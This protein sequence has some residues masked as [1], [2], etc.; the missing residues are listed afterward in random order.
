MQFVRD[1]IAAPNSP[2]APPGIAPSLARLAYNRLGFG[3]RPGDP[4]FNDAVALNAYIDAQINIEAIDDATC[5]AAVAALPRK[6]S[7]GGDMPPLNGTTQQIKAYDD[8]SEGRDVYANGEMSN[9]LIKVTHMRALLSKKQLYEVMVDFWTNHFNTTLSESLY[10]YW[11]DNHVI[12]KY[13]LTNFRDI[14]GAS[15]KS[16]AMLSFLSNRYSD[17]NNP[18]ENYGRELME[19][20]TLGSVNRI[21]G[22]AN[23]GKNNYT[24]VDVHRVA[25]VLSGWTNVRS[26]DDGFR[27]NDTPEWPSHDFTR[28]T[29]EEM[30]NKYSTPLLVVSFCSYSGYV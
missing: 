28:D 18:N 9:Y 2:E 7:K 8:A 1:L 24:E 22:H 29:S 19:L 20:H 13:A 5:D 12:R 15:A 11:E 30:L 25:G 26:D 16:P 21:P 4:D 3:A 27:F 17:G 6:D 10:K 23:N 14:L